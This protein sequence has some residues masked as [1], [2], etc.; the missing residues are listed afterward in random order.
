MANL[1][2]PRGLAADAQS[3]GFSGPAGGMRT[4]VAG[5]R[6][7]QALEFDRGTT[8]FD[9]TMILEPF[10]FMVWETFYIRK[11]QRVIPFDME[12]DSGYGAAAHTCQI[13]PGSYKANRTAGV[14]WAVAFQVEATSQAFELTD[15]QV[16]NLL[17]LNETYGSELQYLLHR[18]AIFANEDTNVLDF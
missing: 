18:L 15:A 1:Q 17:A 2:F 13:I 6:G 5:G 14:C 3:Y 8:L 11:V 10:Q 12:L 7:R 16:D 4:A 9:V